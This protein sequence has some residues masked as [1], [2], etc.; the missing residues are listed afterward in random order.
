MFNLEQ[1]LQYF[2]TREPSGPLYGM[3]SDL[4]SYEDGD[5]TPFRIQ[6][7]LTREMGGSSD[8]VAHAVEIRRIG[9]VEKHIIKTKPD[10]REGGHGNQV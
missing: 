4:T 9:T 8:W 7:W 1:L 3:Y 6:T 10:G 2:H 5:W